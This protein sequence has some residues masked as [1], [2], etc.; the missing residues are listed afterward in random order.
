MLRSLRQEDGFTCIS[1]ERKKECEGW[2][3]PRG[4]MGKLDSQW[5]SIRWR[6]WCLYLVTLLNAQCWAWSQLLHTNVGYIKSNTSTSKVIAVKEG[7]ANHGLPVAL[8]WSARTLDL[9]PILN[10]EVWP[11][12]TRTRYLRQKDKLQ[13]TID[14]VNIWTDKRVDET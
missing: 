8:L 11:R 5:C 1:R 2:S 3:Y 6:S 4:K 9:L 13:V 10:E 12:Q 14:S 7:S